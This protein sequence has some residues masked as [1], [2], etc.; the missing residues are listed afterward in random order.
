[1]IVRFVDI[2]AVTAL[3]GGV[4]WTFKVKNDSE[5]AF[6][7]VAALERQI[8]REREA[9]DLLKADWSLLTSPD[10]LERLVDRHSIELGLE[11]AQPKQFIRLHEIPVRLAPPQEPE[12]HALDAPEPVLQ[13]PAIT[14]SIQRR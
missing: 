14:G 10:R 4:A 12:R 2:L 11:Q 6:A 13:V 5:H 8:E 9:I 7:R 1:M 3:L